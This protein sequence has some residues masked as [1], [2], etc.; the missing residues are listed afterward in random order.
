[1]DIGYVVTDAAKWEVDPARTASK[2][3]IAYYRGLLEKAWR[4]AAF[5][6]CQL[7]LKGGSRIILVSLIP[8]CHKSLWS[9]WFASKNIVLACID[10]NLNPLKIPFNWCVTAYRKVPVN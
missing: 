6:F 10:S 4:E 2:F 9:I 8:E 7:R 5:V 1:M 3:Y